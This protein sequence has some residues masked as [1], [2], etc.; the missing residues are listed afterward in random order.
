MRSRS[1]RSVAWGV[2]LSSGE[3][4]V[5]IFRMPNVCDRSAESITSKLVVAFRETDREREARGGARGRWRRVGECALGVLGTCDMFRGTTKLKKHDDT[6]D[7]INTALHPKHKHEVQ[8]RKTRYTDTHI[9]RTQ[10]SRNPEH[11]TY[12]HDFNVKHT[13]SH[14]S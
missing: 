6:K 2:A 13:Y 10:K 14:T 8:K 12:T 9:T 5:R 3:A 11:A 7:N 1:V 4:P